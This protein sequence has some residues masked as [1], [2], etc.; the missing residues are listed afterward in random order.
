MADNEKIIKS[1]QAWREE[2]DAAAVR[3]FAAARHRARVHG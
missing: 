3:R 2:S 1:D